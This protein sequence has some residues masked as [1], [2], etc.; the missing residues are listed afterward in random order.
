ML[1]H[2]LFARRLQTWLLP[3]SC[4]CVCHLC[5]TIFGLC[6]RETAFHWQ[7]LL[8][9]VP[10]SQT[11]GLEHDASV[12]L[13]ELKVAYAGLYSFVLHYVALCLARFASP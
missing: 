12:I 3:V 2:P 9:Y 13:E 6:N 4:F 7:A 8:E 5:C 11:M 10:L 1:S